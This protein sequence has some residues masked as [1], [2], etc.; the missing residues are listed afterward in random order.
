MIV[1]EKK[2]SLIVFLET[3]LPSTTKLTSRL[4]E[5]DL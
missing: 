2:L 1:S 5:Q 4:L 3:I